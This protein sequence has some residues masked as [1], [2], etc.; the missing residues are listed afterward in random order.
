MEINFWSQDNMLEFWRYV[1]FL[2]SEVS[3]GV[4]LAFAVTAV[5]FL[6]PVVF[7][8]FKK[9]DDDLASRDYELREY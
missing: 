9:S 4:M 3:P 7:R 1:R 5:S 8:A 2:L 6:I